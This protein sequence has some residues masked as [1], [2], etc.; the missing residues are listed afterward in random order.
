VP[1]CY[2]L[3]G[4]QP[5]RKHGPANDKYAISFRHM[6]FS[7]SAALLGLICGSTQ[8]CAN[9]GETV[10]FRC[11]GD[12]RK[13]GPASRVGTIQAE[14]GYIGIPTLL[15]LLARPPLM[16]DHGVKT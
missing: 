3:T 4:Q 1:G 6:H 11:S 5:A 7:C 15:R 8:I 12:R 10:S 2:E 9:G 14:A 13:S 16:G